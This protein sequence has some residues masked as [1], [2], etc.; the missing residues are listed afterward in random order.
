MVEERKKPQKRKSEKIPKA[1]P[2]STGQAAPFGGEYV[3]DGTSG[4]PGAGASSS[5]K[6][7]SSPSRRK[8]RRRW[9]TVLAGCLIAAVL[10]L[11]GLVAWDRWFRFDDKADIQG[12]WQVLPT[13]G[14]VTINGEYINLSPDVRY[15][16]VLDPTAKTIT[17]TFNDLKGNGRYQFTQDRNELVIVE[18]E[19]SS[20]V[21]D[22]QRTLGLK[23]FEETG[24]ASKTTILVRSGHAQAA[25]G[26]EAPSGAGQ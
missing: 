21:D 4:A 22:V 24:D 16:Y 11:A 3:E 5:R 25:Q 12:S 26:T 6:A 18:G 10:V 17:F 20:I 7:K 9:P 19:S 8:H 15:K 13:S 1:Q 23:P 2:A 14:A